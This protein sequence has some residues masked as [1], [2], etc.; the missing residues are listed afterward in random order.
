ML[1]DFLFYV[2]QTW[3]I[4][5]R[6]KAKKILMKFRNQSEKRVHCKC[7][8]GKY[9]WRAAPNHPSTP[10]VLLARVSS[11]SRVFN[12]SS[13]K[14]TSPERVIHTSPERVIHFRTRRPI[15]PPWTCF[16]CQT[17]AKG[18]SSAN[19]E[20]QQCLRGRGRKGG[21]GRGC[22]VIL[23]LEYHEIMKELDLQ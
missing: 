23:D 5:R 2:L 22:D 17:D 12:Q 18:K 6:T 9:V 10:T 20:Q 4:N 8:R 15:K 19:W 11:K 3:F 14:Q 21:Q 7:V 16:T 13:T 1:L